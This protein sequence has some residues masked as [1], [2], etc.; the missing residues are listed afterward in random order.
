MNSADL[1]SSK[2][3]WLLKGFKKKKRSR[4]RKTA[5]EQIQTDPDVM[6][7]QLKAFM[8]ALFKLSTANVEGRCKRQDFLLRGRHQA[9]AQRQL[10]KQ[11]SLEQCPA[12]MLLW[13]WMG[14]SFGGPTATSESLL[15]WPTFRVWWG[16]LQSAQKRSMSSH[17][18]AVSFLTPPN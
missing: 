5:V 7:W 8:R 4:R 2:N 9:W 3:D 15:K 11:H 12:F 10:P 16:N 6:W 18:I 14:N 1:Y 17:K 13:V